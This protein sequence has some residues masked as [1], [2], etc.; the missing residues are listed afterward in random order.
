MGCATKELCNL[1]EPEEC[2]AVSR[3]EELRRFHAFKRVMHAA[4]HDEAVH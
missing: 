1:F 2:E 3:C 4:V